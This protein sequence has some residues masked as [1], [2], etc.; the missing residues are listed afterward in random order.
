MIIVDTVGTGALVPAE[1]RDAAS[2]VEELARTI[3]GS[4]AALARLDVEAATGMDDDG[5]D[6]RGTLGEEVGSAD[7][8]TASN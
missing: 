7:M 2:I 5:L 6:V 3:I 8:A 4:Q 1:E